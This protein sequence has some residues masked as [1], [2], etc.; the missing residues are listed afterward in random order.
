[1]I[2]YRIHFGG[3]NLKE[4]ESQNKQY[5]ET[6]LYKKDQGLKIFYGNIMVHDGF[7]NQLKKQSDEEK[8]ILPKLLEECIKWAEKKN[9]K[10]VTRSNVKNFLESK[11]VNLSFLNQNIILNEVNFQ[12]NS[13]KK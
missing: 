11:G 9:F 3:E 8:K 2:Y 12:L 10:K 6:S 7:R 4:R 13:R 1:M 5:K